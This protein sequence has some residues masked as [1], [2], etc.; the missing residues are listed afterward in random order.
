[1]RR[2]LTNAG[3]AHLKRRM[4]KLPEVM[5]TRAEGAL[6]ASADE[7]VREI[8]AVAPRRS[9][10][11]ADSIEKVPLP[12]GEGRVGWRVVGGRKNGKGWY[13]RF[14][15][16]GTKPSPGEAPSRNRNY[17]RTVVMTKGKR[18]HAGT[19][20]QPFFWP[21]YRRLRARMRGRVTRA[22]KKGAEE[23]Q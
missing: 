6:E 18:A 23:A 1:M 5:R 21:T 11:L 13:I 10:D 3:R 9:G 19:P 16:H 12:E 14:V 22:L 20:A 8:Q 4:L 7:L 15:E 2:P 17:R